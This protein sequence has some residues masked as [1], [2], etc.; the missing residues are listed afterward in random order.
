MDARFPWDGDVQITVNASRHFALRLRVPDWCPTASLFVNGQVESG[1]ND[2]G[3]LRL[4]RDWSA[5]DDVRLSLAMP[6]RWLS[7]RPQLMA[8]LGRVALQRGPF[9][10]VSRRR[11]QAWTSK[12]S[13]SM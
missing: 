7:A 1:M 4:E 3:Y 9:S 5:G 6:A 12:G 2:R 13:W 11:M 10:T 8:D